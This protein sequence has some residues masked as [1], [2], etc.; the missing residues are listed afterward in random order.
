MESTNYIDLLLKK[1]S[2]LEQPY[3]FTPNPDSN[4]NHFKEIASFS[5]KTSAKSGIPATRVNA[6][7]QH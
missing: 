2:T 5:E 4:Y 3:N 7:S 1:K 6:I